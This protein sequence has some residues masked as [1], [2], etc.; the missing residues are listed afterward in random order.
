[1]SEGPIGVL[2]E[3]AGGAAVARALL[4][5]LPSEDVV[6][7]ADHAYAPY[8]RKAARV[9]ADR[10]PRM[11]AELV[12]LGAKLLVV[13]SLQAT[14]DALDAVAAAAGVPTLGLEATL[15]SAAVRASTGRIGFLYAAGT[16]REGPW[17]RANRFQR[18]GGEV[19][20]L[21]WEGLAASIEAG[22]LPVDAAEQVGRV[23]DAGADVLVLG[24]PY[25]VAAR[26]AVEPLL[27]DLVLVDAADVAVER[28]RTHLV[29]HAGLVRAR[30]RAGRIRTVTTHPARAQ[31]GL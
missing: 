14:D 6:V 24:C 3:G 29:R 25:A 27:G 7:L 20:A 18:G 12:T 15:P 30:R 5:C 23:R 21:A 11:A 10:A 31:G 19:V 28:V 13:A 9:V 2:A 16:L 22:R 26:P 1:V 17:L 8:A 4:A